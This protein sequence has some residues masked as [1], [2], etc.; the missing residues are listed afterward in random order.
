MLQS[1]EA[2]VARFA[3]RNQGLASIQGSVPNDFAD[4]GLALLTSRPWKRYSMQRA[5]IQL[6]VDICRFQ[7]TMPEH[8]GHLLE[9]G[10]APYHLCRGRVSKRVSAQTASSDPCEFEMAF[11]NATDSCRTS[12]AAERCTCA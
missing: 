7:E 2:T 11:R 4:P 6:R 8:I 3:S 9:A 1:P 5:L 12:N 10:S